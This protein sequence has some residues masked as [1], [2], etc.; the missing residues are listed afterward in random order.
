M[1]WVEGFINYAHNQTISTSEQIR[2]PRHFKKMV[3][4]Q[5]VASSSHKYVHCDLTF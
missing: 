5:A 1:I 3:Y 2:V 4:D